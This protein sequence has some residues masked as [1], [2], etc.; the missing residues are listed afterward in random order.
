MAGG[1]RHPRPGDVGARAMAR[2][3]RGA[4]A[5]DDAVD[6][7]PASA[8]QGYLKK[9]LPVLLDA[10]ALTDAAVEEAVD[11]AAG[12]IGRFASDGGVQALFVES[13][14]E[15]DE[16]DDGNVPPGTPLRFLLDLS[17]GDADA[18]AG[19]L[20]V[21]V[22][23]SAGP[24]DAEKAMS[25]QLQVLSLPSVNMADPASDPLLS[26]IHIFTKHALMPVVKRRAAQQLDQH[27]G[28]G[29]GAGEDG[30]ATG[31][32]PSRAQRSEPVQKVQKKFKELELALL[33]CS[34]RLD[35]PAVSLEAPPAVS[36]ALSRL[37]GGALERAG[38]A[39]DASVL[40]SEQSLSRVD[41]GE[42]GLAQSAEDERFLDGATK[43][44]QLWIGDLQRLVGVVAQ[45]PRAQDW[46]GPS[47]SVGEGAGQS[48]AWAPPA[49]PL[50]DESAAPEALRAR[51]ASESSVPAMDE[52]H[53]WSNVE[54]SL[55]GVEAELGSA[56]VV[57]T[58]RVLQQR[59]G[60]HRSVV[61]QLR[62]R[63]RELVAVRSACADVAKELR[64][65]AQ[66]ER[67]P[68]LQDLLSS[69]DLSEVEGSVR[70]LF[71]Q[72]RRLVRLTRY[73]VE[74]TA[75]LLVS[76]A[77]SLCLHL[78]AMFG[79]AQVLR[80]PYD[81]WK[82]SYA[83][84]LAVLE[85][86]E[87]CQRS[88][89]EEILSTESAGAQNVRVQR[90][91]AQVRLC[92]KPL[93]ER[94]HEISDFRDAH[95]RLQRTMRAVLGA[96]G[97][98]AEVL[99][100]IAD[101]YALHMGADHLNALDASEGGSEAW[102]GAKQ[103]YE[104]LIRGVD[105]RVTARLRA[106]LD[107]ARTADERFRVFDAFN[108]LF[109]RPRIKAAIGQ[110]QAPLL[111]S[112]R[113]AVQALQDK[114]ATPYSASGAG[115]A[116]S[117]RDLPAVSSE[118]LWARQIGAQ[119]RMLVR[120]TEDVLGDAWRVDPAGRELANKFSHLG[121][122]LQQ[123]QHLK[124]WLSDWLDRV[125]ASLRPEKQA[126][127]KHLLFVE[128]GTSGERLLSVNFD[129]RRVELFKEVR[130]LRN[131]MG[132]A[133]AKDEAS[134][135]RVPP[136]IQNMALFAQRQYPTAMALQ[137]TL[138]AFYACRCARAS[139]R[140]R[141]AAGAE[142]DDVTP[143]VIP[144]L[145]RLRGIVDKAFTR[146]GVASIA[147]LEV[148]W[149]AFDEGSSKGAGVHRWASA[150]HQE[151]LV[152]E[153]KVQGVC[154]AFEAFG[155]RLDGLSTCAYDGDAFGAHLAALQGLV[156]AMDEAGHSNLH[157][158]VRDLNDRA[159]A[160]L[161]ARL[162]AALGAFCAAYAP[163][164]EEEEEEED[165]EG[166]AAA[167]VDGA[168]ARRLAQARS[169]LEIRLSKGMLH[170]QPSLQ[171][172]RAAWMAE[173]RRLVGAA[174]DL[175]RL[176][177]GSLRFS[178][179][180]AARPTFA[181]RVLGELGAAALSPAY[182][183]VQAQLALCG[184][185]VR[186]WLRYQALWDMKM[187][188]LVDAVGS[189]AGDAAT[190]GAWA[191]LLREN[192]AARGG[193]EKAETEV[194]FGPLVVDYGQVQERVVSRYD[195][196]AQQLQAKFAALLSEGILA[197]RE[198][199]GAAKA[200]LERVRMGALN[201]A[202]TEGIVAI[203]EALD[204][205]EALAERLRVAMDG[206]KLLRR[207]RFDLG[208]AWPQASNVQG[209][210]GDVEQVLALRAQD[211]DA[212]ISA[213]WAEVRERSEEVSGA[214]AA[215]AADWAESKPEGEDGAGAELTTEA[216][217][218]AISRF[219][220]GGRELRAR[221]TQV[222][223]ARAALA[224]RLQQTGSAADLGAGDI[225]ARGKRLGTVEKE[226]TR[227]KDVW[228]TLSD[229]W[230][231]VVE[232]GEGSLEDVKPLK[233]RMA[234]EAVLSQQLLNQDVCPSW[235]TQYAPY[236]QMLQKV[237]SYVKV[238]PVLKSLVEGP[239]KPRHW[240]TICRRILKT[241][242]KKA[243]LLVADI[244]NG[245][246]LEQ[247]AAL[248][249]VL[250]QA[251]GESAIEEF[252]GREVRDFWE[253]YR[254]ELVAFQNR[255]NLI[256]S[257]E[258]VFEKLEEHSSGLN[259]MKQS[260][261][262]KNVLDFQQ[263]ARTWE[264]RIAKLQAIF[265]VWV[266]VQR[267]WVYLV[268]VFSGSADIKAQLPNE[269][270]LFR[271][272]DSDFVKLQRR[273]AAEPSCME[274]LELNEPN[275]ALLRQL[276]RM[277]ALMNKTQK[278]LGDYLEKQRQQFSRF[279][280]VGDDDL[281]EVIGNAGAP[282]KVAAHL[283]K[284]FAAIASLNFDGEELASAMVSREGEVVRLADPVLVGE[285]V[286]A[287]DWLRALEVQMQR[288]VAS[289]LRGALEALPEVPKGA[290][291][292]AV[293]AYCDW[294][295][296]HPTQV[297][298]LA[299]QVAWS[300]AAEACLQRRSK[301]AAAMKKVEDGVDA[302][303]QALAG[304]VLKDIGGLLRKKCEQLI[305]ELV[306]SRD[307]QRALIDDGVKSEDDFRWLK[308]LRLSWNPEGTV[309]A[310]A[311][312]AVDA[313]DAALS[314][315]MANAS[316]CYGFEY[317]GV[318]ERLVTTPLTDRCYLTL[319][320]ALHLRMGGN[321]YGPAGTGKTESVKQL[322]A[323]LGRFVLTFVVG[324]SFDY[325]AM[326]RIFVGL[327]QVGA[328]GCFDEINRLEERILSA[329]SQQILTIQ[330]GLQVG[331]GAIDLV[332]R[333]VRL[334]PNVGIFVTLNPGYAGRSNLPDNLK[335]LFRAVAMAVPDS[336][337]I[338]QVMLFGQGVVHAEELSTDVVRLFQ[339]CQERL[340]KQSHYD[341]GL[342]ALKT[343]LVAAG[344]LKRRRVES[345][346]AQQRE[347]GDDAFYLDVE[348]IAAIER[349]ALIRS[350]CSTMVP[351]LVPEDLEAFKDTLDETFAGD[352]AQALAGDAEGLRATLLA[353]G[354]RSRLLP[355]STW[356]DKV[357]Q[358]RDVLAMRNGVMLVGPSCSGKSSALRLLCAAMPDTDGRKCEM[359]VI[360]PK[361]LSKEELYGK[362]DK[363]T[364]EWTDGVFTRTLRGVLANK[365]GGAA[366][367]HWIVFDG[368]VDP[369]W[370]EDLNSV[371][372][373]NRL[374]TLPNGERL[375]IPPNL[376]II[377]EVDTLKYATLA[378]VSRCGM[379]WFSDATVSP[380]MM[381]W[382]LLERVASA[383]DA[384]AAFAAEIAPLVVPEAD[385]DQTL[386]S[387]ALS[388]VLEN[389][390]ACRHVMDVSEG[391]LL[392]SLYGLLAR[393][394]ALAAE[395]N[396]AHPDFPMDGAHLSAFA[397]H[398][399][400]FSVLWGMGASMSWDSRGALSALLRERSAVPLPSEDLLQLRVR[401]EDGEWESWAASVP[402]V[403]LEPHQV[404]SA[405]VVVTT[406]DVVR[407]REVLRAWLA[408]R[409][410]LVLCGPPGS[411]KTMTLSS[412]LRSMTDVVFAELNFS[413]G[414]T[415]ALL[416]KTFAAYC[417][418]VRTVRGPIL[419]PHANF[420]P[421]A[422]LVVF[423]DEINLP[424]ADDY[425]TQRVI[426][427]MR[428]LTEQGGFWRGTTWVSLNRVQFVGACNPPE[429]AGR[430]ALSPR[431]LRHAPVL[432]VDFPSQ[433]SLQ[434][435]YGTFNAALLKLHP[436]L[437]GFAQQLTDAMIELYR[438]NQRRFL[439]AEQPQYF[440]SPREMS[441]WVRALYEALEQ[442]DDASPEQLVR[443]WAHEALRLFS[444]RLTGEEERAWC[445]DAVR[446]TAERHFGV[447]GVDI[448]GALRSPIL[449]SRWTTK[450]Q[451]SVE[452]EALADFVKA[453]LRVFYEE[454]LDVPLVVFDEVL[455][456][457][458][459][460]D[461][462]LRQPMG[463]LLLVGDAGVGKTVLSRFAAWMNGLSIFQ[464][465]AHARYTVESF[466]EDLRACMKRVGC[467]GEKV[468]F[469]FDES[470]SL[471]SGFLERMNALLASGEVP[472]LF[473]GDELAQLLTQCRE[474]AQ[475]EGEAVGDGDEELF[476]R[477]TRKVQRNL[478]VVFTMNPASADFSNRCTTS[479][480]LYNRCVVDWFGT[481]S[482]G[483]LAEVAH[484]LGYVDTDTGDESAAY[485]PPVGSGELLGAVDALLEREGGGAITMRHA[486]TAALVAVHGSVRKVAEQSGA[487][488][489][490][491]YVSP[492]DF[493]DL[494]SNFASIAR[495]KRA[496]LEDQARHIGQGLGRLEDAAASVAALQV[497][498]QTKAAELEK[499][500]AA[501]NQK[502]QEMVA[503]QN[504][505]ERRK[506][507][508]DRL[509]VQLEQR[510]AEV[511]MKRGPI[512]QEL[513]E[514]EP[515]LKAAQDSVQG[516]KKQQLDEVRVLAR[517]P[518]A[519]RATLEMVMAMIGEDAREWSDIRRVIRRDDFIRTVVNYNSED[520]TSQQVR[521]VKAILEEAK[522]LD[523]DTATRASR[524][525]GPLFCWVRS[526]I[527]YAE[528][529]R[530]I[531]PLQEE[532]LSLEEEAKA[533]EGER[534]EVM[535]EIGGL[536]REIRRLKEEYAG[537]IG[538]AERLKTEMD[539]VSHKVERA[540]ALLRSLESERERWQDTQKKFR[541]R[542]RSLCGDAL[543]A[544][545]FLT[546]AAG[547]PVRD[548][549]QL[550]RSWRSTL[551]ALAIPFRGELDVVEWL[552]PSDDAKVQWRSQ[553][554][555]EERSSL[556]NAIAFEHGKRFPLVLDGDG[557]AWPWLRKQAE[558]IG[559]F[560]DDNFVKVLTAAIRF[561]QTLLVRD[562]EK[563]DPVINPV[564]NREVIHNGGRVCIQLAG[565]LVDW[566]P[567][568]KL[569]LV[570][571]GSA[572]GRL[573]PDLQSRV[574]LVDWRISEEGLANWVVDKVLE[575]E[576]AD[577]V[578]RKRSLVAE[579]AREGARL[580]GM[581]ETL[582]ERISSSEGDLLADDSLLGVLQQLKTEWEDSRAKK[583]DGEG[584]L[585]DLQDREQEWA[586]FGQAVA[587]TWQVLL[588]MAEN[589]IYVFDDLA[590]FRSLVGAVIGQKREG[591]SR[592][593]REA[594]LRSGLLRQVWR[595]FAISLAKADQDAFSQRLA[596]ATGAALD[597]ATLPDPAEVGAE[598]GKPLLVVEEGGGG[599]AGEDSLSLGTAEAREEALRRVR[600]D[601]A[602][603]A[604]PLKLVNVH[605]DM[606]LLDALAAV[607]ALPP[608]LTLTAEP[609]T[610]WG[611]Y[612]AL[613][614]KAVIWRREPSMRSLLRQRPEDMPPARRFYV[615]VATY[616]KAQR[617]G[618]KL[619]PLR[620]LLPLLRASQEDF[621]AMNLPLIR[622]LFAEASSGGAEDRF[623]ALFDEFS[624]LL[625]TEDVFPLSL[626]SPSEFEEAL[627][628]ME[629]SG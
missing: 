369:L 86:W 337:L 108:P 528:I 344:Q 168:L 449:F 388:F 255:A 482:A 489:T 278:A 625:S 265:D 89:R 125:N 469:I 239:L 245:R 309:V 202:V 433:E 297:V 28:A 228:S 280:F 151:V 328:W 418:E 160:V 16:N 349:D 437:R 575:Q 460:I 467:K 221:L 391:T 20:L 232:L 334:H 256:R 443:L 441:R 8:L 363:T 588:A 578:E 463:H 555:P 227:L 359:H 348:E 331:A 17:G 87:S 3:K 123:R 427:F 547:F 518:A 267:R 315:S 107:G 616:W 598:A 572:A 521:K 409:K 376:R 412:T 198:E 523:E 527:Q 11:G 498:M 399:L 179:R 434:Q 582:L 480:A 127:A 479:P 589:P 185:Y 150:L 567:N 129:R 602:G 374:L 347:G 459:R 248:N 361:A 594:G 396:E 497:S 421:E 90:K 592:T 137:A 52:V 85:E 444:D 22:K 389:R 162:R 483:A 180:G 436:P 233:L 526:Q 26:G 362:L 212:R 112:V 23:R 84:F 579:V 120:K 190:L 214:V 496:H 453:K 273:V 564:L 515:T 546:Y 571:G 494:L 188:Q 295:D 407:H 65:L 525:C 247:K 314:V 5:K 613:L 448:G 92:K 9:S 259:S 415:K 605:Y 395:Y 163:A 167:P 225:E 270:H 488:A 510:G 63:R 37:E 576:D 119:L 484:E 612:P 237:R 43:Q 79:D 381:L 366:K 208:A 446:Q 401:V 404:R 541:S 102:R 509:R 512:E 203:Q 33:Q 258:E 18:R 499:Q 70:V 513:L 243:D 580:R 375:S 216:A 522:G 326:G 532:V 519:I 98:G 171:A 538:E 155:D 386:V 410:P 279:Y 76:C 537:M 77:V 540:Q 316:F 147:G 286:P 130:N 144:Q 345:V 124:D 619:P 106:Q 624:S 153:D 277:Q 138:D 75:E 338:A 100:S 141:G 560:G 378:T 419:Q 554:L 451:T 461:R 574:T 481:W 80:L 294:V 101:A 403:E 452:R 36:A 596:E 544:S 210:L 117:I 397:Q 298:V 507:D 35:I 93:E 591:R 629:Q 56:G 478:H 236:Q 529:L 416:L 10:P 135:Q 595:R 535:A 57:V 226:L 116:A 184:D 466:D 429:D 55:A 573:P 292:D 428:Q 414:T 54:A 609:S 357:L 200:R 352:N 476:R 400:L 307:V 565:D 24:L 353:H 293:A 317:L 308:H 159:E 464:V 503:Q 272:V 457:V 471:S 103:G 82:R 7:A 27:A 550:S 601:R 402:S 500:D 492:R 186:G 194:R 6:S 113:D 60:W 139:A 506:A 533:L 118:M 622:A 558:V 539:S 335:Q 610:I 222:S 408:S 406:T 64:S 296:R 569:I 48:G 83:A 577:L 370:A 183:A 439:P 94:L 244:W 31:G 157:A 542:M 393:G 238:N 175:P 377:M 586:A 205:R 336:Q 356:V 384:A 491:R 311:G 530:R 58:L 330:R 50:A 251:T 142:D 44:A 224:K 32:A 438:E 262:F 599:E 495:E 477:F 310:E 53:F 195:A 61:E 114:F 475:A 590:E 266:D 161:T 234:L 470:N 252:L 511:E 490:R 620:F 531:R 275:D 66:P 617:Q 136:S 220:E 420:G 435:I 390:D 192:E 597:D 417:E 556:E 178:S 13:A 423:C 81:E 319:T 110:Y 189:D 148:S 261:H 109:F 97:D 156:D 360:D 218:A 305:T 246:L 206:E 615:A 566:N 355:E 169:V 450:A 182:G 283:G 253:T 351:K 325:A 562:V 486:L 321:P 128:R 587:D 603:G 25:R 204:G 465:K 563:L 191:A 320:Q 318:G 431:F 304:A 42:L 111:E 394:A 4:P 581:E 122:L 264:E 442:M 411:G 78:E 332:G 69:G 440:Y 584:L 502:L 382:Q 536:E 456:H 134:E 350:V 611:S 269:Y 501:A 95:E 607:P 231:G 1:R 263:E 364:L 15:S 516:I 21:L 606:E 235:L 358:L 181:S 340:S 627:L 583:S 302:Q 365:R 145:R 209:L 46:S 217:L 211:L 549:E 241:R 473:E 600:A 383:S 285:D 306:H 371:L 196:W 91:L 380:R 626:R 303:L 324:E 561:G 172:A 545:A 313:A 219:E 445:A 608:T 552:T 67:G 229:V 197:L 301:Q 367:M 2:R 430:V 585:R 199:L 354:E 223:R 62:E 455:D 49:F 472:G 105:D 149:S 468:C 342:R 143:F 493:L 300:R 121:D 254:L 45:F 387:A 623:E 372:D 133:G 164:A 447:G 548:R 329:I 312:A 176:V 51:Y 230:R 146:G 385:D 368:D 152:L 543:L 39:G 392:E 88:L 104:R 341:F 140:W 240:T 557:V 174:C 29:A 193:I 534:D 504:E 373:D 115:F 343:V 287:K 553:G 432:L 618:V 520:V 593:A 173:L 426:S 288:T 422:W 508:A 268:G 323:Q 379:V 30:D 257:F 327:C 19:P 38:A 474:A 271:S 72:C 126:R 284:M 559:S 551:V 289:E 425:G 47:I 158:L 339:R 424:Q 514:V 290:G 71:A 242:A 333:S 166:A 250:A 249:E 462:V 187:Q 398:W 41:L 621:E 524:A 215:F 40:Q 299:Q 413:S 201:D 73:G 131:V 276:E 177:P 346:V 99:Q 207:Q 458:L 568:F 96:D 322:G 517:P 132:D 570:D 614:R 59:G 454:E 282:Q 74:R 12:P 505:A 165:G 34:Q 68:G 628:A 291:E 281:L 14:A 485:E 170:V 260:P 604:R 274:V 405:D 213:L 487:K 154:Q